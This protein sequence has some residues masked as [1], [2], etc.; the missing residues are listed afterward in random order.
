MINFI[1]T[2]TISFLMKFDNIRKKDKKEG[3]SVKKTFQTY[4]TI[5]IILVCLS[6][7]Y[8]LWWLIKDTCFLRFSQNK[9]IGLQNTR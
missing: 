2:Q 5:I 7:I 3:I 6:K 8:V 4:G 9:M 1:F